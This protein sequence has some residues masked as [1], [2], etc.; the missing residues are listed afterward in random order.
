MTSQTYEQIIVEG[1]KGL[2]QEMLAEIA[3]FVYF[4]RKRATQPQAYEEELLS[5]LLNA[6][7]RQMS[8]DEEEHLDEEFRDYDR[9]YPRN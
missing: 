6:E 9:R 4:I 7:L 2:P 8:R 3:D 1:I 5:V